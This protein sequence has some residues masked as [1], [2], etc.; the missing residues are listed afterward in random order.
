VS[1]AIT[2]RVAVTTVAIDGQVG[3]PAEV[4]AAEAAIAAAAAMSECGLCVEVQ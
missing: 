2:A 1:A 4:V 3:A